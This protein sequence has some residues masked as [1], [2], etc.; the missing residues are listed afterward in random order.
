MKTTILILLTCITLFSCNKSNCKS[1]SLGKVAYVDSA[2]IAVPDIFTPN[3]DGINDLL[4]VIQRNITSV[5]FT[6][7]HNNRVE[8]QSTSLS[9][10]WDGMYKGKQAKE[11]TYSYNVQASTTSGRSLSLA[12]E[13][14]LIRD[15]CSKTPLSA[16]AFASQFNFNSAS[17]DPNL[18]SFESIKECK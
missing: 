12:G 9:S 4:I 7:K 1:C 3:A 14:C 2:Y 18:S 15:N 17:F 11:K 6:I 5:Q 16:C 10:G 13:I 8:F